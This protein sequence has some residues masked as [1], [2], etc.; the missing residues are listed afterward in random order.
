V[1]GGGV[2]AGHNV[3]EQHPKPQQRS[4]AAGQGLLQ[5]AWAKAHELRMPSWHKE[6]DKAPPGAPCLCSVLL[7]Y[8]VF[9]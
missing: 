1:G 4:A 2:V 8:A 5:G 3:F 7:P 6:A 9:F